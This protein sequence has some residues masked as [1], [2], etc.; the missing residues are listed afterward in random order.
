MTD[1]T[2]I[3]LR[4]PNSEKMPTRFSPWTRPPGGGGE[5]RRTHL[6]RWRIGVE[7]RGTVIRV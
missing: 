6:A 5:V 3:F 7:T 4:R 2:F 1:Q